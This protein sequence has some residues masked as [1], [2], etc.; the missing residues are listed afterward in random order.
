M[1]LRAFDT[2]DVDFDLDRYARLEAQL[3]AARTVAARAFAQGFT[4]AQ[5]PDAAEWRD[6]FEER[7]DA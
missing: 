2:S 7:S 3:R 4:A 1:R 5:D 6:H